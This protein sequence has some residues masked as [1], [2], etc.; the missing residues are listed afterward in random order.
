MGKKKMKKVIPFTVMTTMFLSATLPA[1]AAS[2]FV[3][4]DWDLGIV[5][6]RKEKLD[7]TDDAIKRRKEWQKRAASSSELMNADVRAT[8][9]ELRSSKVIEATPSQLIMPRVSVSASLGN[10]W[11]NWDV[12]D[13]SFLDG[14]HGLG[15]KQKPYQIRTKHQLMGLSFL[16]AFGMQPDYGEVEEEIVGDYRGAWF[17]LTANI[18]LG[19]MDWNPIGYYR[20]DSEFSGEV[21]HPFTANLDGNG[22][23]ISNFRFA[24]GSSPNVG[25]FGALDGAEIRNLMLE[26]GKPVKGVRQVGILAGNAKNSKIFNCQ[27]KGDVEGTGAVGGMI[28]H[29]EGSTV[30]NGTAQVTV[31]TTG[32]AAGAQ[33]LAGGIAGEAADDSRII[34]CQV[35]TGDNSTSRIQGTDATVG[36]I[37]GLQ[38]GAALY[39]TYVN[40]T[41]GGSGSQNVGGLVGERISGDLKV[42]R[43][44]GTIGQS[45]TGAAGHRGT[46]IGYRAPANYF[47]YGDDIAY[48]FADTEAKIA[49]NVCGSGI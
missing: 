35:R 7:D 5:S 47:K 41:I 45:G 48:L 1:F 24:G 32:R 9:S 27:V 16:A 23:K 17:E 42:G 13:L 37:V 38:N 6:E 36:G 14:T 49:N 2:G 29:M 3:F 21:T 39:N 28:G 12:V 33:A 10:L 19:G 25:F 31:R 11:E 40:G 30:E 34:D 22:Y 26:P 46:F 8:P 15:T 43:F 44:E 18:D 20:D 4:E